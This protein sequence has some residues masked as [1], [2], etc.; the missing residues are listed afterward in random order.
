MIIENER[1]KVAAFILLIAFLLTITAG[2][3]P[4]KTLGSNADLDP[5]THTVFAEFGTTTW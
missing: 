3:I 1:C 4:K 2:L 5:F